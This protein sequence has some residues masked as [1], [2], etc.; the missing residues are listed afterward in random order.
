MN[1]SNVDKRFSHSSD[2]VDEI[3]NAF[4]SD[5]A[6]KFIVFTGKNK[7]EKK[8]FI[9]KLRKI[10]TEVE[11]IDL[12]DII[13]TVEEETF[14]NLEELFNSLSDGKIVYLNNGDVLSGEYTGNTYSFRRYATPQE[15][16]LLKKIENSNSGFILDLLDE[17][18]VNNLLERKSSSVIE[19]KP[20]KGGL[21]KL[22][23]RLKQVSLNGHTFE[24]KRPLKK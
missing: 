14:E 12:R 7:S 19:F 21:G 9:S 17:A 18:N 4:I 1:S 3:L 8:N 22:F 24:N 16:Y 13:S 20:P 5:P 10:D 2:K 11:E 15:K 23:W 6:G